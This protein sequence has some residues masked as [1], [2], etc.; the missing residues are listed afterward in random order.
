[1]NNILLINWRDIKNPEAGGAERYLHEIFKRIAAKGYNIT[2]LSHYFKGALSEEIID[3]IKVIRR[4]GKFLFNYAVIPYLLNNS[5]EYDLII[6]DLNK[7]PFLTPLYVKKKRLH[8]VMHFFGKRIFREAF[9]PLAL[10]VYIMEK[11]VTVFYRKENFIAISN[12]TAKEI[13]MFLSKSKRIEIIEPGIDVNFFKPVC[14][15]SEKNV[16]VHVGRLMKYKNIQFVLKALPEIIKVIKDLT[17]E[18]AGYGDYLD[19]LR[20]I[21]KD[22][23]ISDRVIFYGRVSEEKKREILSKA[24]LFVNPSYKE[25]WGINNIEANLCGTISLSADVA[26]LRDSVIDG[27]T[28]LLYKPDDILDF[29]EKAI[30]LLSDIS[31]RQKMEDSARKRALSLTWEN[32]T[33]KMEKCI[34]RML[35]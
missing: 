24:T 25:G 27:V 32:A 4:G 21:A 16:M 3:G 17:F 8:M 14:S 30:K 6:E 23:G 20:K 11:M 13:K 9:F 35:S 31:L 19:T 12:S 26:G 1:M 5:K 33:E 15:K 29:S 18:I 22:Y 7:L 2:L 10:Y 34:L 28:G